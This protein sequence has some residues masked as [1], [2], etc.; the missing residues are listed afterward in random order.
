[1]ASHPR[2]KSDYVFV[3]SK[4]TGK[5]GVRHADEFSPHPHTSLPLQACVLHYI[6][7]ARTQICRCSDPSR[8]FEKKFNVASESTHLNASLLLYMNR[9]SFDSC[10]I[11]DFH[12]YREGRK[13]QWVKDGVYVDSFH[14][15]DREKVIICRCSEPFH[16]YSTPR[17]PEIV[18]RCAEY[19]CLHKGKTEV[20]KREWK[21][22]GGDSPPAY[23][24]GSQH[25]SH[26]TAQ[27][28]AG[29]SYSPEMEMRDPAKRIAPIGRTP[30]TTKQSEPEMPPE[31][32]QNARPSICIPGYGT[33][34]AQSTPMGSALSVTPAVPP[35][36]PAKIRRIHQPTPLD[37]SR[38]SSTATYW[39]NIQRDTGVSGEEEC[40]DTPRVYH[41]RTDSALDASVQRGIGEL[42][43][44]FPN[45]RTS[46]A[47]AT[48]GAPFFVTEL[49]P[50]SA[51][52][53]KDGDEPAYQSPAPGLSGRMSAPFGYDSYYEEASRTPRFEKGDEVSVSS[54]DMS[55]PVG[56][57]DY[58]GVF[59]TPVRTPVA[60]LPVDRFAAD[61][62]AQPVRQRDTATL[63]NL[64]G[65][66]WDTASEPDAKAKRSTIRVVRI[67]KPVT[68][69]KS[70]SATNSVRISSLFTQVLDIAGSSLPNQEEFLPS[71]C[72][73]F[74]SH[75][76]CAC[77]GL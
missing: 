64:E 36:M 38:Q 2:S 35:P 23:S 76:P 50:T 58:D 11:T 46:I 56:F 33:L 49:D 71:T 51:V 37:R 43:G 75:E 44:S 30:C 5:I 39:S 26:Y 74:I 69:R 16:G 32:W 77:R 8:H 45:P 48:L 34:S 22:I 52:F 7:A 31:V 29:S 4:R 6:G 9:H 17:N 12:K 25:V 15:V 65:W 14:Y 28:Q 54:G 27:T 61:L 3:R 62:P 59:G 72:Y 24:S 70:I 68:H 40:P 53:E 41:Q 57:D 66:D 18:E 21:V 1:M 47:G 10:S 13:A 55:I 67:E 19:F 60:E 20:S 63:K 73:P 42:S